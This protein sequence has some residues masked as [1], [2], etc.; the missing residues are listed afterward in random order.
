[1]TSKSV[2]A[3]F[4]LL[5]IGCATSKSSYDQVRDNSPQSIEVSIGSSIF[6]TEA[7]R[8][9]LTK[10]GK[11][12]SEKRTFLGSWKVKSTQISSAKTDSIFAITSRQDFNSLPQNID[13]NCTVS[14]LDS[15]QVRKAIGG[16]MTDQYTKSIRFKNPTESKTIVWK[17]C[18]SLTES[19][20]DKLKS[21][22]Y[23][24]EEYKLILKQNEQISSNLSLLN[25]LLNT[26]FSINN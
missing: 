26:M 2:L 14:Y 9:F 25:S 4:L 6:G 7:S 20:L 5:C 3:L 13:Q 23:S 17:E 15:N 10:E 24:E 21:E 16:T 8:V 22:V 12:I 18:R 19:E 1:M 11:L